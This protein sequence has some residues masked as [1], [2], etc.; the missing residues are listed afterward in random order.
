MKNAD[1]MLW[2]IEPTDKVC[3][4]VPPASDTVLRWPRHNT[5]RSTAAYSVRDYRQG[6]SRAI[7]EDQSRCAGLKLSISSKIFWAISS[8]VR[9]SCST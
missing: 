1:R 8:I 9:K 4:R 3:D 2:N 6:Q 5:K 7:H